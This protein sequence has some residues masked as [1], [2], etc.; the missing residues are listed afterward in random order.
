MFF[1][2]DQDINAKSY[3][4]SKDRKRKYAVISEGFIKTS[5]DLRWRSFDVNYSGSTVVTVMISGKNLICAN[6]GDSW[7]VL[8]SHRNW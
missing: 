7:A 6:V 4:L 1:N 8:G 3:L 5:V 2:D